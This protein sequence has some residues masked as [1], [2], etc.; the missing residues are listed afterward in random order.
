MFGSSRRRATYSFGNDFIAT[1]A[2]DFVY[3]A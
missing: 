3:I 2:V 1:M